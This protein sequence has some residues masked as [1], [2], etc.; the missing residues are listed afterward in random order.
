ME[1]VAGALF[2][3]RTWAGLSRL[4][5]GR[6]ARNVG[7]ERP[8]DLGRPALRT[9]ASALRASAV[10]SAS[11]SSLSFGYLL[12]LRLQLYRPTDW[13]MAIDGHQFAGRLYGAQAHTPVAGDAA[14][15]REL[16]DK[17]SRWKPMKHLRAPD[18][19]E[20]EQQQQEEEEEEEEEETSWRNKG[21]GGRRPIGSRSDR[22]GGRHKGIA[23][24][25]WIGLVNPRGMWDA[26]SSKTKPNRTE[27]NQN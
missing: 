13:R 5:A 21:G 7:R 22:A 23:L 3:E 16:A 9:A 2:N 25:N 4:G 27:P 11:T 17:A 15:Q 1:T 12:R 14:G 10:A 8:P 20:E 6:A 26:A 18:E 19:E 24:L